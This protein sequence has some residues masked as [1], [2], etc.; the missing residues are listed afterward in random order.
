MTAPP[1]AQVALR[2]RVERVLNQR[3]VHYVHEDKFWESKN[4]GQAVYGWGTRIAR[5]RF[6]RSV[7]I[8]FDGLD[9]D[10]AIWRGGKYFEWR[11]LEDVEQVLAE[12]EIQLRGLL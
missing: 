11:D 12:V 1:A 5:G 9:S 7:Y 2:A 3:G 6:T 8:W 4:G 10:I